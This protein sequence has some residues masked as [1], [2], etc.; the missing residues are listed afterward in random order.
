MFF[1]HRLRPTCAGGTCPSLRHGLRWGP[2]GADLGGGDDANVRVLLVIG[3][4]KTHL[5]PLVE[6]LR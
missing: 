4:K 2:Q 3:G 5:R 1:L 6:R